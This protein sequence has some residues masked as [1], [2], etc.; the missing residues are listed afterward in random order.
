MG[1]EMVT[2]SDRRLVKGFSCLIRFKS[3]QYITCPFISISGNDMELNERNGPK[4]TN[5][6]ASKPM[7]HINVWI[8]AIIALIATTSSC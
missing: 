4:N 2:E 7:S 6:K 3:T 8:Y 1:W 5:G